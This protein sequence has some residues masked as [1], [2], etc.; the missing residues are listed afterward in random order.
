MSSR[1]K[2]RNE[3]RKEMPEVRTKEQHADYLR[4]QEEKLMQHLDRRMVLANVPAVKEMIEEAYQQGLVEGGQR[5]IQMV[6]PGV[7]MSLKEECGFGKMRI[8]RVL[9]ALEGHIQYA[10]NHAE[11]CEK[12]MEE[13]G[14]EIDV[15]DMFARVKK[16]EETR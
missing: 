14:I 5:L 3:F 12:L 6:Y 10:L 1:S 8:F 13:Y 4:E 16:K 7:A 2:R 15:D 9:E 11:L